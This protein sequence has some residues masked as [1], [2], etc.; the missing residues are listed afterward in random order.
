MK[1]T[2]RISVMTRAL[3]IAAAA[4]SVGA[5][6]GC[7]AQKHNDVL[8]VQNVSYTPDGS[9]VLFTAL[10]IHVYR[11]GVETSKIPMDALP[12]ASG[13]R[14]YGFSLAAGGTAAAVAYSFWNNSFN[15]GVAIYQIPDGTVLNTFELANAGTVGAGTVGAV[16]LSPDG[17][18]LYAQ[19]PD[20]SK[21]LDTAT[22][23]SLWTDTG[24][25]YLPVWS[26]DGTTLF[27]TGAALSDTT[28]MT[29][30]TL[31]ARDAAT[32]AVKWT[33]D[34]G[35]T[36]L[37]GLAV[38]GDGTLLAGTSEVPDDTP[39]PPVSAGPACPPGFPLWSVADGTL[40]GQSSGEPQTSPYA[41]L[42]L[43]A[44]GCNATDTCATGIRDYRKPNN[45]EYARVYKTDGTVVAEVPAQGAA[46]SVAVS[47]DGKLI[48]VASDV[49]SQDSAQV[50]S[51][52][53]GKLVESIDFPGTPYVF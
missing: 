25:V 47:P 44:F 42:H 17:K 2:N 12:A 14:G 23:A 29:D 37:V 27:S 50:F 33:V 34:L 7:G 52:P 4:A 32:G 53:D 39:C 8:P 20:V 5:L 19:W 46:P 35:T 48:A 18:L 36:S 22:G 26:A 24:G 49:Y 41:S 30:N 6:S 15:A 21:M 38:V 9:L 11:G 3:A 10:A 28:H 40:A 13:Q 45:P 43:S 51:L 31:S 16:S 1:T